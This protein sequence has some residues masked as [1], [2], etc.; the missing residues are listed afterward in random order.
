MPTMT[1]DIAHVQKG[2][3]VIWNA[4]RL[5]VEEEPKRGA[6]SIRLSGRRSDGGCPYVRQWYMTGRTVRVERA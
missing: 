4:Y 2:D 5:R 6:G 3:I 1:V